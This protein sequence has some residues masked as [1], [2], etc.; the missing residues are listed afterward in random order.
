MRKYL[1]DVVEDVSDLLNKIES[2]D[3]FVYNHS[4]NYN[5]SIINLIQEI[6][7]NL[8]DPDELIDS[9]LINNLIEKVDY[10]LRDEN[11][12]NPDKEILSEII[13]ILKRTL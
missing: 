6:I 13:K 3:D 12:N 11:I 7:E 2:L 8:E 5:K 4:K 1:G 10:L 9:D